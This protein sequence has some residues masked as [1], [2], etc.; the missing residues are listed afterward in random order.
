MKFIVSIILVSVCLFSC[1]NKKEKHFID[2][3]WLYENSKKGSEITF[4]NGLYY[5]IKWDDDLVYKSKGKYYFN[6]NKNRSE[7]TLT[8]VPDLQYSQGDTI[9]LPCE[10]MDIVNLTD[11]ILAIKKISQWLY[12]DNLQ[13]VVGNDNIVKYKKVHVSN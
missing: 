2:G 6:E 11:S 13:K 3:M 12:Q 8:L 1:I 9:I 4:N 7:V 5:Q 10:N